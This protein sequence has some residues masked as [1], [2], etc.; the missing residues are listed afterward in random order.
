MKVVRVS[1]A[2]LLLSGL[3]A[4]CAEPPPAIDPGVS[5]TLAKHR[6][7]TISGINY[8]LSLAIPGSRDEAIE[9]VVVITFQLGDSS[10]PLQ[11]DFRESAD[12][13]RGVIANGDD[14]DYRFINEHIVIPANELVAGSNEIRIEFTAGSSSLNRNPDY[15]YSLFVPDRARTA[16]PLFDQPDLKATFELDLAIP[17][18]WTAM[19]N[20]PVADIVKTEDRQVYRFARSDLISSYV[21]AFVAGKF[22]TVTRDVGGRQMTMLHRETDKEKVARNVDEIFSLHAG[23]LDWL[24]DY[25][26]IDYPYDKFDFALIPDFQYGGME[27]VGAILYRASRLFLEE[28]PSDTQLLG[29]AS[30]IAHEAAHMWFGNLVTMEWFNDVWTKEVF[31]NFMAAKIVNPQ[32][33]DINHD[34]NFLVRHYPSAYSVDRT[35]GANAVRQEL[36]NLNEAGQMYGAIIYN[37]AP[38]MMRKL[39]KLIGEDRFREGV[40]E[41]LAT[42]AFGNATWPA[43]VEILDGKSAEDLRAWSDAWVHAPGR[44]AVESQWDTPAEGEGGPFRYGLVPASIEDL[45]SDDEVVRAATLLN[46]Y[47]GLLAE[48]GPGAPQYLRELVSVVRREQN[49]LVLD[50]ALDQLRTTYWTLLAPATREE[51]APLLEQ[52]LWETMLDHG[53]PSRRKVLF[54]A[55]A[56]I[57]LTPDGLARARD[58]WSGAASVEKLTL[59]ENDLIGMAQSLAVRLPDEAQDIVDIQV[60]RTGNPDNL[61]KLEFLTPSLSADPAVRDEFFASLADE[62]NRSVESW[63][64]EALANLHHPVRSEASERYIL[65]SL[66]LLQEIQVTGDIFFPKRWLD[67]TLRSYHSTSAVTTVRTFLAERPDYNAQLRMKILQAADML[68]RAN[69]IVGAQHTD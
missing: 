19:A 12:T 56:A 11:L 39:E 42:F 60:A 20:A 46:L 36:P 55:F 43:L 17:A 38:I 34:L 30:L 10:Q 33:P 54:E 26:G 40:R 37:K 48:T 53:E 13:I 16:F 35:A 6:A 58:V 25:T 7:E 57:A 22:E 65:P 62:A 31:A 3:M 14:S 41:Y 2:L 68:F 1:A 4:S 5:L 15:L 29:R 24:E 59:A 67:V 63:V 44:K 52:A 21:F 18:D 32:F 64:L 45:R 66:E 28:A 27:H 47:E 61:R 69:S 50:L 51:F 9:G 49:D 23:A 8:A